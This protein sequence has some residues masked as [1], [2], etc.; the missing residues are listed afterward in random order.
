MVHGAVHVAE[1]VAEER[2]ADLASQLGHKFLALYPDIHLPTNNE[3]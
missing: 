3:R 1:R 2:V